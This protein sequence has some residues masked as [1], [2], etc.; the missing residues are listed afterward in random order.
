M[1]EYPIPM[2]PGPVKLPAP[3]L[4][5]ANVNYGAADLE[6]EFLD[7]Y[8]ETESALARI[9]KTKNRVVIASGEG[10]L[11]LWA[12]LKSCLRPG[13]RVIAI[14]TGLFGEGIGRMAAGLGA[15]VR[16]IGLPYDQTLGDVTE[17]EEAIKEFRPKM[18]T[19]VH[20]ETPSGTLNPLEEVGR[21][22]REYEV[23][24]FYVDAVSSIGG[25][26]VSVDE[27]SI[28]LALGGA[29]KCLSAP[30]S[31]AFISVSQGA[32][33]IIDEIDYD[34]YDALKPFRTAQESFYFPYTPNWHGIAGL[35]AGAKLILEEGLEE[36]FARHHTVADYCRTRLAEMDLGL[37]PAPDAVQSPTVTAVNLPTGWEWK[38]FDARLRAQGLVVGGSYGPMAGKVFRLGHMGSQARMEIAKAALDVI[39]NVLERKG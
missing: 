37:F 1:K 13:D 4:A 21:L 29:Q 25:T 18:I 31:T 39:G 14:S 32:W 17:L 23:P 10:M 5:A 26:D 27:N 36:C 3:V 8:N 12:G 11:V 24:L 2:V 33:E 34:G 9:M 35:N 22:K 15:E 28:D 6:T 19:M 30:P 38:D 7:L 16:I 20:C